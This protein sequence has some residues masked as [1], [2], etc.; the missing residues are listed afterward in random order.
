MMRLAKV[1]K[2]SAILFPVMRW[3][4]R[5][6]SLMNSSTMYWRHGSEN[7]KLMPAGM[8]EPALRERIDFVVI[9]LSALA[10]LAMTQH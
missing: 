5:E 4:R 2:H 6:K 9:S 10:R 1:Q 8:T 7:I 3:R